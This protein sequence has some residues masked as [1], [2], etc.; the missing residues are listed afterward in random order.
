MFFFF[1]QK[2][3]DEMRISDWSSDV[4]SSDLVGREPRFPDAPIALA[5]LCSESVV[6]GTDKYQ[7][8]SRPRLPKLKS[9]E[10]NSTGNGPGCFAFSVP[11]PP[12]DRTSVV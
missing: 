8:Q 5:I 3:A 4:C 12:A 9:M 11:L 1:K 6:H 7:S 10:H 2:T